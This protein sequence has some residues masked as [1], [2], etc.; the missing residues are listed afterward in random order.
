MT[1]GGVVVLWSNGQPALATH[2]FD[3]DGLELGRRLVEDWG[4]DRISTRHASVTC[5]HDR[6][7]LTDLGSRNGTW[8]DDALRITGPTRLKLPALVRCGRSLFL[9]VEDLAPYEGR[10]I[11]ER[12]RLVV[13]AT[14]HEPCNQLDRAI[15]DEDSVAIVGPRW[16]ARTLARAY[17]AAHDGGTELH[18]ESITTPLEHALAIGSPTKVVLLERPDL[19]APDDLATLRTW[20]ETDVRFVTCVGREAE[21]DALPPEILRW[22]APVTIRITQP[23]YDELPS[24]VFSAVQ[25]ANLA[26]AIHSSAISE[27]LIAARTRDEDDLLEVLGQ[28][29]KL[30]QSLGESTLRAGAG[31]DTLSPVGDQA[32]ADRMPRSLRDVHM[33]PANWWNRR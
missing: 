28:R 5:K 27:L 13:G 33:I 20:L 11:I 30:V 16:V 29:I 24:V 7:T 32:L 12:H 9:V 21:L 10:S 1:R 22:L 18:A 3:D 2:A 19:L 14:L 17:L 15:L 26:M 8:V 6:Y 31:Y 23:R 4:D 25:R